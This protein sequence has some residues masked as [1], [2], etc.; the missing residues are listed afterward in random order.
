MLV[1]LDLDFANI[2]AY[3]PGH[4]AGIIVLRLNRQ[5]KVAIV[6]LLRRVLSVLQERNPLGE[7][8]IV[9]QNRIRFR[10]IGCYWRRAHAT[11]SPLS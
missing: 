2:Q 10:L 7:L 5:D 1:T 3:P 6:S 9:Q 8:W 11:S 4:D